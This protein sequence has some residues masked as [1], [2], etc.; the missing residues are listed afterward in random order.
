MRVLNVYRDRAAEKRAASEH[1]GDSEN[2]TCC[3]HV[4]REVVVFL[5]K[6]KLRGWVPA[7]IKL[8][9]ALHPPN[10]KGTQAC[11]TAHPEKMGLVRTDCNSKE[12][13][14]KTRGAARTSLTDA[15]EVGE[16]AIGKS[17]K[18]SFAFSTNF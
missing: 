10:P 2:A 18:T 13:F 6:E 9:T 4:Y 5:S 12:S 1:F 11:R 3:P 15:L 7:G 8:I 14:I 16:L 17:S